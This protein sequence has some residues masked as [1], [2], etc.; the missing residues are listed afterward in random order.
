MPAV[1]AS[2]DDAHRTTASP[3]SNTVGL[4]LACQNNRYHWNKS[5]NLLILT[6]PCTMPGTDNQREGT[7][8]S[9]CWIQVDRRLIAP[10]L[11]T[12]DRRTESC[13][14]GYVPWLFV[15]SK[16][17][18]VSCLSARARLLTMMAVASGTP[19]VSGG[20]LP[21][22]GMVFDIRRRVLVTLSHPAPAPH[23]GKHACRGEANVRPQPCRDAVRTLVS[24]PTSSCIQRSQRGP[25]ATRVGPFGGD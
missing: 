1:R 22:F 5:R 15:L 23:E 14:F 7:A 12:G 16:S 20:P 2:G 13:R 25:S 6:T 4:R 10:R 21:W 3:T 17:Q 18:P 11:A 19:S 9:R 8:R 24:N